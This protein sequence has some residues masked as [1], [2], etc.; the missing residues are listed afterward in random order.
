MLKLYSEQMMS[1]ICLL[2]PF[3]ISFRMTFLSNALISCFSAS[4]ILFSSNFK[5]PGRK[6]EGCPPPDMAGS[7]SFFHLPVRKSAA[8]R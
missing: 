2:P 1:W 4:Q 5:T 8:A 7:V 6:Q 3:S